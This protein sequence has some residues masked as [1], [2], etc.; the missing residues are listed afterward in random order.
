M[1]QC[2]CAW[3]SLSLSLCRAV[4]RAEWTRTSA[5]R[6]ATCPSPRPWSLSP[7]TRARSM[8]RGWSCC[9]GSSRPSQPKVTAQCMGNKCTTLFNLAEARQCNT[10]KRLTKSFHQ[11]GVWTAAVDTVWIANSLMVSKCCQT[12]SFLSQHCV[13]F[14]LTAWSV[15]S[16]RRKW[17]DRATA[18]TRRGYQTNWTVEQNITRQIAHRRLSQSRTPAKETLHNL[19]PSGSWA[20]SWYILFSAPMLPMLRYLLFSSPIPPMEYFT[21]T[22]TIQ[23]HV[24]LTPKDEVNSMFF[25]QRFESSKI[26]GHPFCTYRKFCNTGLYSISGQSLTLAGSRCRQS[27]I[28]QRSLLEDFLSR[29]KESWGA[30]P[31]R[32]LSPNHTHKAS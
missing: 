24:D 16:S 30:D 25:C 22:R 12:G 32:I 3:Q 1:N 7:T 10:E 23:W 18:I 4:R 20:M 21:V 19:F 6:C 26:Q 13:T 15:S 17:L 14:R 5:A 28:V 31:G 11:R 2:L 29:S 8:P 9:W 27:Q